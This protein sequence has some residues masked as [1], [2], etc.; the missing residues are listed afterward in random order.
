MPRLKRSFIY[1]TRYTV[2]RERRSGVAPDALINFRKVHWKANCNL[3]IGTRSMMFG[4]L[5]FDRENASITIGDETYV[6]ASTLVCAT[7]IQIGSQVLVSWGATIVDHDSHSLSFADRQNDPRD[8]YNGHKSWK[9]VASAPVKIED[10]AWIGFGAIILKG[11]TIGARAVVGAGAVVAKDVPPY[12][13]VVGN[14]ARIVRNLP[15][16]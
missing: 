13:V 9:N 5:H 4:S 2:S 8:W 14:P 15:A 7:S 1:A 10:G 16:E 6:G 11:V 12:A 3:V